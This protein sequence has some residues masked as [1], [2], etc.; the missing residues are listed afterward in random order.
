MITD[1]NSIEISNLVKVKSSSNISSMARKRVESLERNLKAYHGV[2]VVKTIQKSTCDIE[3]SGEN[4]IFSTKTNDLEM[5][6]EGCLYIHTCQ[7]LRAF[8]TSKKY[9]LR[10]GFPIPFSKLIE[11]C[12]DDNNLFEEP[13]RYLDNIVY[14]IVRIEMGSQDQKKIPDLKLRGGGSRKPVP[15]KK[16]VSGVEEINCA[17]N[18]LR[19]VGSIQMKNNHEKCAV[20]K[21]CS[22]CLLR[23]CLSKINTTK[24]RKTVV[25]VEVESEHYQKIFPRALTVIVK[26]VLEKALLNSD[27]FLPLCKPAWFCTLC[28]ENVPD[29]NDLFCDIESVSNERNIETL[30]KLKMEK[31]LN[32]HLFHTDDVNKHSEALGFIQMSDKQS[33]IIFTSSSMN[34]NLNETLLIGSHNWHCV[35]ILS[36]EGKIY[37]RHDNN[38]YDASDLTE[39][40]VLD[41]MNSVLAIYEKTFFL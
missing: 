7:T 36:K 19:S 30:F 13:L 17:L 37:F 10:N 9:S 27:H 20:L 16:I 14:H 38:W 31:L 5:K 24:G 33:T 21:N 25:P 1:I 6:S 23:S 34:V 40:V 18:C 22:T 15:P 41:K 3:N 12:V 11:K 29:G 35:S 4:V 2:D 8:L 26:Q 32:Y 28:N 39:V